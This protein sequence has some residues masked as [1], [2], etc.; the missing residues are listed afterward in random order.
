MDTKVAPAI[1]SIFTVDDVTP[2]VDIASSTVYVD[3]TE[4]TTIINYAPAGTSTLILDGVFE[5]I[6]ILKEYQEYMFSKC[7]GNHFLLRKIGCQIF[8]KRGSSDFKTGHPIFHGNRKIGH[9]FL[10]G[11]IRFIFCETKSVFLF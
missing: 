6:L 1:S 9:P 10:K 2:T 5:C 8:L 3:N 11:V 7:E 4:D